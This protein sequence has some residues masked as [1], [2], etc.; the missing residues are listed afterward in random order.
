MKTSRLGSPVSGSR[1]TRFSR[2]I[3]SVTSFA[4]AYQ[5]SPCALPLHRSQ[6]QLPSRWRWRASSSTKPSLPARRAG[7]AA[8]GRGGVVRVEVVKQRLADQLLRLA[9]ED[10]LAG[11]VDGD[12]ARLAV[13]DREQAAG[14]V[15]QLLVGLRV[16]PGRLLAGGRGGSPRAVGDQPERHEVDALPVRLFRAH[17]PRRHSSAFAPSGL[18]FAVD[19]RPAWVT[20][21]HGPVTLAHPCAGG[22]GHP[23]AGCDPHRGAGRRPGCRDLPRR[24]VCAQWPDPLG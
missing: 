6:R 20:S 4:A 17:V 8:D 23:C 21:W 16:E 10:P 24:A 9:A 7:G 22:R 11:S 13:E 3:H 1:P 18:S 5:R 14:V 15:E 19:Q 2:R 12:E